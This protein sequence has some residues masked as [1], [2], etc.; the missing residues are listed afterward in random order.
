MCIESNLGL[1][2]QMLG[3]EGFLIWIRKLQKAHT[4]IFEYI[5]E[6]T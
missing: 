1:R 3:I 4:L 5:E 6:K 2:A